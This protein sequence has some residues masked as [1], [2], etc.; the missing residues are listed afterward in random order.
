MLGWW[1]ITRA[2]K[3][4]EAGDQVRRFKDHWAT[5]GRPSLGVSSSP[6]VIYPGARY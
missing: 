5:V 3:S 1:N 6:A 4:S 2:I